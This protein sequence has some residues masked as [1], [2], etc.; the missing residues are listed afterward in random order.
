MKKAVAARLG[1]RY[2]LNTLPETGAL[3]QIQFSIMKDTAMLMLDTSG[4]GLH[5]RGYRAQGVAA[6][7][8]ETLAAAMVLLSRYRAG[9]PCATPSAARAPSPSRPLSSPKTGPPA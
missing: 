9:I 3:Y 6:P 5:K 8:R 1:A 7:L 4:A 2:G